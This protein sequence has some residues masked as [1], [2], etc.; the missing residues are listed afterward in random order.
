VDARIPLIVLV[1]LTTR[2]WWGWMVAAPAFLTATWL[3]GTLAANVYRG[4]DGWVINAVLFAVAIFVSSVLAGRTL[5]R[6]AAAVAHA[7]QARVEAEDDRVRAET[8]ADAQRR[9]FA[10]AVQ[11][12]VPLLCALGSGEADPADPVVQQ[13]CRDE[14]GYLRGLVTVSRAP[15]GVRDEMGDLLHRAHVRRAAIVVRG[16]LGQ[17][18]RPSQSIATALRALPA[19]LEGA[20]ALE[21]T[22]VT[23]EG[24]GI[25]MLHLPGGRLTDTA[26]PLAAGWSVQVDDEDGPWLEISWQADAAWPPEASSPPAS[27]SRIPARS[28]ASP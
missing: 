20:T 7:H 28:V 25:V 10:P 6:Q 4:C 8:T 5:R 21:V 13:R 15:D 9:W 27:P 16:D 17:L 3:A 23:A 14:S 26:L 1:M 18:P 22:A 19:D 12:C 11:A 2:F 24:G